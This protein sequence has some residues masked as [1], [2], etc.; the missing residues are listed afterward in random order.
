MSKLL[1][2]DHGGE[3]A[4]TTLDAI[5]ALDE[6]SIRSAHWIDNGASVCRLGVEITEENDSGWFRS[7]NAQHR[8]S[9]LRGHHDR[10]LD[11]A[12]QTRCHDSRSMCR[13][14]DAT[15]LRLMNCLWRRRTARCNESRGFDPDPVDSP[16]RQLG[17]EDG[18]GKGTSAGIPLAEE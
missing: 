11:A 14:I 3:L 1:C 10:E 6:Q 7:G 2:D 16:L 5:E 13:E 12:N 9:L 8:P 4:D 18:G 15:A 17:V